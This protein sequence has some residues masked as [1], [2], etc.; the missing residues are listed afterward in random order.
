VLL[1][2][3][4]HLVLLAE[5]AYLDVLDLLVL[6]VMLEKKEQ[7]V[8]PDLMEPLDPVEAL[9]PLADAVIANN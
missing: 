9:V 3:K 7:M 6:Q 4:V 1:D 8:Y 5:M 2:L